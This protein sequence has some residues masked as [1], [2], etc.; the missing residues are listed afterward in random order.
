MSPYSGSSA[1]YVDLRRWHLARRAHSASFGNSR[2]H[3][4]V[5]GSNILFGCSVTVRVT[6]YLNEPEVVS[7]EALLQKTINLMLQLSLLRVSILKQC[8]VPAKLTSG[9]KRLNGASMM[10]VSFLPRN[11]RSSSC[12]FYSTDRTQQGSRSPSALFAGRKEQHRSS[13]TSIAYG[14]PAVMLSAQL[15]CRQW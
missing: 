2:G 10:I 1:Q 3:Q 11:K 12:Q 6:L 13:L 9:I 14:D 7:N 4:P 15:I 5:L 8:T